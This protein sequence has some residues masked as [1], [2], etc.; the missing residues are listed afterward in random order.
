MLTP[1]ERVIGRV[2]TGH[3]NIVAPPDETHENAGTMFG[4]GVSSAWAN[5]KQAYDKRIS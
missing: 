3:S 2:G 1:S 5:E 4:S